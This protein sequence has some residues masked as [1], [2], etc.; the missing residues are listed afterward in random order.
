MSAARI[1]RLLRRAVFAPAPA[2]P[3]P[4][5]GDRPRTGGGPPRPRAF[6]SPPAQ[7]SLEAELARLDGRAA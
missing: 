3:P 6:G 4:A 7:P 5:R 2:A 1:A